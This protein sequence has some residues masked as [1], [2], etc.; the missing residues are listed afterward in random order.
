M[1]SCASSLVMLALTVTLFGC[2][3]GGPELAGVTGVVK[4]N[5]NPVPDAQVAFQPEEGPAAVGT[6]DESGKF[7]L[8]TGGEEGAVVGPGIFTVRAVEKTESA[9]TAGAETTPS[10]DDPAASVAGVEQMMQAEADKEP[11][12]SRIPLKY[13]TP[14]GSDLK[15]TV[16]SD[17]SKNNFTLELKD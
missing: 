10:A 12:K 17:S 1:K 5:G 16:D 7:T 15:F 13:N 3:G 2:G 6:T 4:Y 11:P 14:Q 8:A 9:S